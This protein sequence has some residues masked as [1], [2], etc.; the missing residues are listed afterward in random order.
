MNSSIFVGWSTPDKAVFDQLTSRL[1]DAGMELDEYSRQ[2]RA[3]GR[4]SAVGR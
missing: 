2:V 4:N 1:E 3:G